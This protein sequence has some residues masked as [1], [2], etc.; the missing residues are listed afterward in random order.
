M[1]RFTTDTFNF[2]YILPSAGRIRDLHP[3]EMCA[4]RRTMKSSHAVFSAA[5]LLTII[6][7]NS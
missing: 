6:S 7:Q 1:Q 3:L 2:G 4:N 5:W